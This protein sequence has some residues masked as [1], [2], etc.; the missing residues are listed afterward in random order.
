MPPEVQDRLGRSEGVVY[1]DE[2]AGI[3]K[4]VLALANP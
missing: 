2:N 1:A 3:L 4:N